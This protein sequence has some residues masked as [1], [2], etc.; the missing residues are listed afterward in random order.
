MEK[1]AQG[2][3]HIPKKFIE[4]YHMAISINTIYFMLSPAMYICGGWGHDTLALK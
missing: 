3:Y 4:F 2:C 1:V